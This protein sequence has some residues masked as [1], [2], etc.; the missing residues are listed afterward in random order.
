MLKGH[1]DEYV[2]LATASFLFLEIN[3]LKNNS[4]ILITRADKGNTTVALDKTKYVNGIKPMLSETRTYIPLKKDPTNTTQK[5]VNCP[6]KNWEKKNY[7]NHSMAKLLKSDN[8]LPVRF[9]GLPKVHKPNNPLRPI[10]SFCGSPTYNLASFY[11]KI[12]S[13]NI[14]RSQN[15]FT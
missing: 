7:S 11:S 15:Y 4:N 5:K 9:Y 6:V 8:L 13:N 3:I 14:P 10:G 12:L 2:K 1:S